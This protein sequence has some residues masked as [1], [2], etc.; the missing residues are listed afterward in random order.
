MGLRQPSGQGIGSWQACHEFKPL[1]TK[2]PP[3]RAAMHVK[4]VLELKRSAVGVMVTPKCLGRPPVDRDRRNAHPGFKGSVTQKS[5][6]TTGLTRAVGKPRSHLISI[7]ESG[8]VPA[9]HCE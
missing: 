8:D 6:K 5:L 1:T 9:N 2:D 4:S 7:I 3:C